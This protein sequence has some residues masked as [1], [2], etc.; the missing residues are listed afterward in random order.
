MFFERIKRAL[1][2]R[3]S[4]ATVPTCSC[5]IRPRG[6]GPTVLS[7]SEV[8]RLLSQLDGVIY[9]LGGTSIDGPPAF[10][11]PRWEALMRACDVRRSI[12]TARAERPQP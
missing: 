7:N 2:S 6:P 9:F 1:F 11:S 4:A 10:N 3:A 12:A 5:S 8:D